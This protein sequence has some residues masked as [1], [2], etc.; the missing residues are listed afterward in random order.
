MSFVELY[1][2]L[3]K[4]IDNPNR[5]FKACVRAKR[6]LTDCQLHEGYYKDKV[7][8]E[9]AIKIL[10]SRKLVDLSLLFCGKISLENILKKDFAT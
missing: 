2:D 5:R 3:E 10:Q 4:Y 1:S 8:F 9:G 7:Y 6:G